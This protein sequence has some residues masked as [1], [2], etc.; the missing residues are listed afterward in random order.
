MSP[1][2]PL[3]LIAALTNGIGE[4]GRERFPVEEAKPVDATERVVPLIV[5]RAIG[6]AVGVTVLLPTTMAGAE[7]EGSRMLELAPG[8]AVARADSYRRLIGQPRVAEMG[9]T[10]SYKPTPRLGSGFQSK[11]QMD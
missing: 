2:S 3:K 9:R 1:P 11:P 8:L 5:G 4:E 7:A 10:W 6:C